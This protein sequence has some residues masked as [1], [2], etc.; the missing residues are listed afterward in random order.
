MNEDTKDLLDLC[1]LNQ[2]EDNKENW[3]GTKADR[4]E[5]QKA[6]DFAKNRSILRVEYSQPP[7]PNNDLIEDHEKVGDDD[8]TD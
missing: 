8:N 4:E 3:V 2:M 5:H 1:R 6:I 7:V